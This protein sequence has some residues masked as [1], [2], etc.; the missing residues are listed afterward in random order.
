MFVVEL[1]ITYSFFT[2]YVNKNSI[3]VLVNEKPFFL[4]ETVKLPL[5]ALPSDKYY[6]A[7]YLKLNGLFWF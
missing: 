3:P 1:L 6:K 2:F 5:T 7:L 4:P